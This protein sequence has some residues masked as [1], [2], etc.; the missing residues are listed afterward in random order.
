MMRTALVPNPLHHVHHGSM[1]VTFVGAR[2]EGLD[3]NIACSEHVWSMS[4]HI[5]INDESNCVS[6]MHKAANETGYAT[7]HTV[8]MNTTSM[9]IKQ[10]TRQAKWCSRGETNDSPMVLIGESRECREVGM[11]RC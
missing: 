3:C 1:E 8:M 4:L 9:S 5:G 10:S 11:T 6:N 2:P 7:T